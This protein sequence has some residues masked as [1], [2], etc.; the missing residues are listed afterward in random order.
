MNL[1]HGLQGAITD[2]N[3]SCCTSGRLDA[4]GQCDGPAKAVDVQNTYTSPQPYSPW[5][6]KLGKRVSEGS[7][8]AKPCVYRVS[9]PSVAAHDHPWLH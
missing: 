8:D 2:R 3:A 5:H 6:V 4:C 1:L 9:K 7:D